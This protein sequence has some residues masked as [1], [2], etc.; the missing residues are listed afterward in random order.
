ML[1]CIVKADVSQMRNTLTNSLAIALRTGGSVDRM[2]IHNYHLQAKVIHPDGS[3]T[4]GESE[5][6]DL[7]NHKIGLPNA[8]WPQLSRHASR[9]RRRTY[10][11]APHRW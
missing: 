9:C 3:D 4:F 11:A 8:T 6:Q 1:D 10:L 5:N 7:V 2:Q